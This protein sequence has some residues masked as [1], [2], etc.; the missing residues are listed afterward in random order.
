[1]S[2]SLTLHPGP[3]LRLLRL[4]SGL[5]LRDLARRIDVSGAYLSRVENGHDATPTVARLESLARELQVPSELLLDLAPGISPLVLDYI[6]RVPEAATLFLE[7]AHRSLDATAIRALRAAL[8]RSTPSS[9]IAHAQR[10]TL[11]SL[12]SPSRVVLDLTCAD[13]DDAFDVATQR[14][15]IDAGLSFVS[16][17]AQLLRREEDVPSA[18]GAGVALPIVCWPGAVPQAVLLT[19][20]PPLRARTPDGVPL[21]TVVLLAGPLKDPMRRAMIV[22]CARLAA[23]GLCTALAACDTADDALLALQQLEES[24]L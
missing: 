2:S 24:I 4:D 13:L 3:I 16:L 8:P 7:I 12:L 23:R 14:L 5:G 22:H 15:E 6:E 10:V 11:H 19:L 18:I 17:S 21:R 20:R 1:M 9:T